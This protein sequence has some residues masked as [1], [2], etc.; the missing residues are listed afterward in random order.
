MKH[1]NLFS[2]IALFCLAAGFV[3]CTKT[4][5][6]NP[7]VE[8]DE[9]ILFVIDEATDKANPEIRESLVR[10]GYIVEVCNPSK[11]DVSAFLPGSVALCYFIGDGFSEEV[12]KPGAAFASHGLNYLGRTELMMDPAFI[13]VAYNSEAVKASSEA[14]VTASLACYERLRGL[15]AYQMAQLES[16]LAQ[17]IVAEPDMPIAIQYYNS[18][19]ELPMSIAELTRTSEN[20]PFVLP[21]S[22]VAL[23]V[24]VCSR[25]VVKSGDRE[26]A[27]PRRMRTALI[28]EK[29][30]IS[31]MS[32]EEG[33]TLVRAGEHAALKSPEEDA[34][35]R[36]AHLLKDMQLVGGR[37]EMVARAEIRDAVAYF[38]DSEI[39]NINVKSGELATAGSI[40]RQRFEEM[41]NLKVIAECERLPYTTQPYLAFNYPELT[42]RAKKFVIYSM[43]HALAAQAIESEFP[44]IEVSDRAAGLLMA[45]DEQKA[46]DSKISSAFN[47]HLA[48]QFADGRAVYLMSAE[49]AGIALRS[50]EKA[51]AAEAGTKILPIFAAKDVFICSNRSLFRA[52]TDSENYF[53]RFLLK[54]RLILSERDKVAEEFLNPGM[55]ED[56]S[57]YE[58]TPDGEH[59]YS[60]FLEAMAAAA[61]MGGDYAIGMRVKGV[62]PVFEQ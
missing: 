12:F 60:S 15:S 32:V 58:Y 20:N 47:E 19:E 43:D 50:G 56:F 23:P 59:Y 22:G 6:E 28:T 30:A 29:F 10:G 1:F 17:R 9:E 14:N 26:E 7:N 4:G 55:A 18:M 48:A 5:N 44:K 62:I 11:P 46:L 16:V 31:P 53:E 52:D 2:A 42:Q 13:T 35:R 37:Y 33:C 8:Q 49:E 39:E 24:F 25:V 41:P 36:Q 3:S 21:V 57:L 40:I 38:R 54:Y 27:I 34:L 61:A 51:E 45:L